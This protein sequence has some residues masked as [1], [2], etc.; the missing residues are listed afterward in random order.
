M[1]YVQTVKGPIAPTDLGKCM[2]HEHILCDYRLSKD[3][4]GKN[5]QWG[6]IMCFDRID[7]MTDEL[8]EYKESGGHSLVEV[9]CLGW[10]RDPEG[11][12][13]LSMKTGVNI[14]ATTGLYVEDCQP[15]WVRSAS[16]EH[17]ASWIER[18][19][20]VGCNGRESNRVTKIKAGIIK[21]SCSRPSFERDE[22]KCLKAAAKAQRRTGAPI[23]SH[24]SASVRFEI[25]SGNIGLQMLEVLEAEGVAPDKVIVGHTDENVDIRNLDAIARKGAYV[26]FDTIGK[27]HYLLDTTR[28]ELVKAMKERGFLK[29]VLLG[30]DRNRKPEMTK[31]GGHGY[32]DIL[33]RFADLL[34]D[35]GLTN[36]ELDT[37][38]TANPA[39]VLSI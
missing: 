17:I 31:Y 2:M 39:R 6:S 18:E 32:S 10:G 23:T 7:E 24:N 36:Q 15:E 1:V 28:A 21:V 8:L 12:L 29:Q 19:I 34:L 4:K 30:Q 16:V 38:L 5:P 14:I 25:E 35:R 3:M 22:L 11:L 20:T 9:T 27:Q 26:Q 13:E 33:N 37:I